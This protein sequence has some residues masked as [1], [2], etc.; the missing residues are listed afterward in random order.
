MRQVMFEKNGSGSRPGLL[1][2]QSIRRDAP[3]RFGGPREATRIDSSN[4]SAKA[5]AA[6]R[7]KRRREIGRRVEA[8][9]AVPVEPVCVFI[10]GPVSILPSP[11]RGEGI[12]RFTCSGTTHSGRSHERYCARRI[13]LPSLCREFSRSRH[14][15]K[16]VL[17]PQWQRWSVAEP[18]SARLC[19]SSCTSSFLISRTSL[20]G[21]PSGRAPDESTGRA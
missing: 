8:N 18:G 4:G 16:T 20:N 2:Y 14:D 10:A 13:V 19:T 1:R 7:R 11:P 21:R 17:G 12:K 15:L 9:G 5:T 6:P 3:R